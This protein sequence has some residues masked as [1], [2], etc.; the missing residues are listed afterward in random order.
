MTKN[1][2]LDKIYYLERIIKDKD[3]EGKCDICPLYDSDKDC[4]PEYN[5][6][7]VEGVNNIRKIIDEYKKQIKD[8]ST[9]KMLVSDLDGTLTDGKLWLDDD[10]GKHRMYNVKDGKGF[11]LISKYGIR[12]VIMTSDYGKDISLRKSQICVDYLYTKCKDDKVKILKSLCDII[13]IS[14]EDIAYV[15]DDI[16]DKEVLEIVGFPFCPA[17]AS[18]C[19]KE[20]PG[21]Y[22]LEKKGG[23]GVIREIAKFILG[24]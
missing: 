6:K 7:T 24:T 14:I 17:D 16:N 4:T 12:T 9:I 21:I 23:E 10:G 20:I 3:C 2:I 22:I 11:K 13:D 18:K 1:E 5:L 15:G 8:F 19:V